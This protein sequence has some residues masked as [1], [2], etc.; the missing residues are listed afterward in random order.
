M[1]LSSARQ[2]WHDAYYQRRESTTAYA[3]EVGILGAMVQKSEKDRRTGVAMDQ[4]LAG[5]VQSAISTLPAHLQCFGHW[6]YSPQADDD[7]REI[8]EELVYAIARSK[9]ERMTEAKSERA[10]YV[11]MG[12]LFRYRRQHQGGQSEGIDPLPTPA[13][14]RGWLLDEHGVKLSCEQWGREWEGFIEHCFQ[15][16]NDLDKRA[17]GPIAMLLASMREAA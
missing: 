12:V 3:L 17:L 15:A 1:K 10:R 2:L 9:V 4:A 14:F 16:C 8:A 13:A 11:A 7:H 6:L 5:V